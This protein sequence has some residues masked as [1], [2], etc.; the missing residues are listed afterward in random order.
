M[1]SLAHS[2]STGASALYSFNPTPPVFKSVIPKNSKETAMTNIKI[3]QV[4]MESSRTGKITFTQEAQMHLD[5]AELTAN[6]KH[7]G[8]SAAAVW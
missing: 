6:V 1:S 3:I 8:R 5:I 7:F 2:S 4:K